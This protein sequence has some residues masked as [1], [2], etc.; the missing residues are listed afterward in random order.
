M[1]SNKFLFVILSILTSTISFA[2]TTN[3]E[4]KNLN[5]KNTDEKTGTISANGKKCYFTTDYLSLSNAIA[6]IG[7]ANAA[8]IVNDYVN[9]EST[10][11]IPSNVYV[12]I[13]EGGYF[14]KISNGSLTF[15]GPFNAGMY[16]VFKGFA[17]GEVLFELGTI[18]KVFPQ[19]WG[20]KGDGITDDYSAINNSL[21][22]F[23]FV[24]FPSGI[25]KINSEVTISKANTTIEFASDV[26]VDISTV[27]GKGTS[28][29]HNKVNILSAF[30]V[31][32]ENIH[33]VGGHIRGNVSYNGKNLAGVLLVNGANNFTIR[34][35]M[36]TR[37]YTSAWVGGGVTDLCIDHIIIDGLSHNLHLGYQEKV[38]EANPQVNRVIISNII[39]K[40]SVNDGLKLAAHCNNVQIV[41]G[42]FY[43]NTKD[44]IDM[45]VAGEYV[46][47]MGV[48]CFNNRVK[49]L[50]VKY[51]S[52]VPGLTGNGLG[53]GGYN[54]RVTIQGCIFTGNVVNAISIAGALI[55]P[56]QPT[57]I[58]ID[59]NIACNS[60]GHAF[61]I[62]ARGCILTNN[63]A[64]GNNARGFNVISSQDIV[65]IGNIAERNCLSSCSEGFNFGL[66]SGTNPPK[67]ERILAIGNIAIGSGT[68]KGQ[69]YGF[70]IKNI[71]NSTFIGNMSNDH[72]SSNWCVG[73]GM[74]GMKFRDNQNYVTEN[75]G[76]SVAIATGGNIKH[77][78]V[79]IPAFVSVTPAEAG[80]KNVTVTADAS[81][82]IVNFEGGGKKRFYWL[83][84]TEYSQ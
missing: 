22:A 6:A 67:S 20:A 37:L 80:P 74:I 83:A 3:Y 10:V 54:R 33:I 1:K 49:G 43:N 8:L 32:A 68:N 81:K 5:K 2:S 41:G 34:D 23:R 84:K 21:G 76:K 38:A 45:F 51:D 39:S 15:D 79:S 35:T 62:H 11:T 24:Y 78:L 60:G 64:V 40:N 61:N 19:W 36:F 82:I 31:S 63:V 53:Q 12:M 14:N 44:G 50:D 69:Q 46:S 58:I 71:E 16:E 55:E 42:Y 13:T 30:K 66:Q 56:F 9:V 25:Y 27:T 29:V 18:E 70:S 77:G 72:A 17:A 52:V 65:L 28:N 73:V 7:N 26:I 57:G 75:A 4:N 48:H 47:I 59:G